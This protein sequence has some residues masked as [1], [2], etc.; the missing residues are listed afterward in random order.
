MAPNL[1]FPQIMLCFFNVYTRLS[2]WCRYLCPEP[3]PEENLDFLR[4]QN[5]RLFQFGIEGKTVISLFLLFFMFINCVEM[6]FVVL[7]L[8]RVVLKWFLMSW[9]I[10]FSWFRWQIFVE[11]LIRSR[12]RALGPVWVF[13]SRSTYRRQNELNFSYKLKLTYN[14]KFLY[15]LSHS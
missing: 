11:M 5:I 10:W 15:K 4:S 1:G 14:L 12:F 3:Y 13:F 8:I 6:C 2:D 9:E 7:Y